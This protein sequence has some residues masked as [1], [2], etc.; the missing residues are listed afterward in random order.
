MFYDMLNISS[1][2]SYILYCHNVLVSGGKPLSRRSYMKQ[3]HE[4]LVKAW[5]KRRLEIPTMPR[6]IKDKIRDV[7]GLNHEEH[8]GGEGQ[9]PTPSFTGTPQTPENSSSMKRKSC[10]LC[11]YKKRRMTKNHCYS[12][13]V[14][15]CREHTIDFCPT[16]AQKI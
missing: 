13:K 16:C 15:I 8:A 5:L 6:K 9:I 4:Q 1:I 10:S 11:S 2:N 3:L 14:P 7:L 12:C